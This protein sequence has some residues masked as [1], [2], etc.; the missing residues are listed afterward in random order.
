[1]ELSENLDHVTLSLTVSL[2]LDP[3]DDAKLQHFERHLSSYIEFYRVLSSCT[4]PKLH[5]FGHSTF[6]Y[7]LCT[8]KLQFIIHIRELNYPYYSYSFL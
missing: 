1:M 8:V 6:F 4:P 3:F 7:Y 5:K 2:S